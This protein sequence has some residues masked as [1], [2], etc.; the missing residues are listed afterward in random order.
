MTAL[1]GISFLALEAIGGT[2][3]LSYGFVN[4]VSAILAVGTIIFLTGLPISYHAAKLGTD[5]D[6]LTRGAGFGYIGSTV[7]SLIYASFTFIFFALEATILS[8]ALELTLD[9]PLTMGY[10]LSSLA[11]IPLVTHGITLISRFQ[12]WTHP[13]WITLQIIPLLCI[14]FKSDDALSLWTGYAPKSVADG[15]D[16]AAFGAA[17]VVVFSLI[18]QVGEQV[19]FLRFLPENNRSR[20][21][22]WM[23]LIFAGPGWIFPGLIKII[24]GSFLAV[25]AIN[26]GI[27]FER[28]SDPNQMY[29]IAFG[30]L[31]STP[32]L[33]LLLTGIFVVL[34]QLKINVTN[35]YAGSIA[36]SNFFSRATQN[37]PGRVVW[38]VFNVVIA[39]MLMELGVYQALKEILGMFAI[40]AI[41]WVGSLVADLTINRP[42][43]LRPRKIEFKRAHLYDINPVGIGSM[44]VASLIGLI[45][46]AGLFGITFQAMSPYLTLTVTFFCAP[47]IAWL[48]KGRYYIARDADSGGN[49]PEQVCCICEH[50]FEPE[51]M[52]LCPAYVGAICSLCCSL[53]SRCHDM[54]KTDAG[55]ADQISLAMKKV[56]PDA[57]SGIVTAKLGNFFG[58]FVL[59]GILMASLLA[60]VYFQITSD[61]SIDKGV[62]TNALIN[63]FFIL[64]IISGVVSWMFSL[65]HESR[66]LALEESR[67][68]TDLLIAEI[69]AHQITDFKLQQA[70]EVA[71]AANQAKSR[72]LTGI[73]HELRSPLNAIL[74]YAQLLEKDQA[75]P[76][77]RRD[78][79]SVIRRSGEHLA[80]LIEGLLDISRIEAGRLQLS[81]NDVD[82]LAML[83][84]IVNMFKVQSLAKGI[85]F[86]HER[87]TPL[88][89]TIRTDEKRLRQILINLIS[90]A[91]KYTQQGEVY[92]S[93]SYRN[94]VAVFSVKD[95]GE[96]IEPDDIEKIFQPFE[97]IRKAGAPYIPGTG[98]GLTITRF[99]TDIMGGEITVESNP[100]Q[101]SLFKVSLMLSSVDT[102]RSP[103]DLL[104]AI[105]S[106]Y[107]GNEQ[108][109]FIVDDDPNHRSLLIDMLQ[110]LGFNVLHAQD[111][112]TCLDMLQYCKKNPQLFLLD[113][114][115]PGMSGWELAGRIRSLIPSAAVIMVSANAYQPNSTFAQHLPHDAY[116]VKPI[117]LTDMMDLIQKY[118]PIRWIYSVDGSVSS[119][120]G[121]N[122][123]PVK[124]G[125]G[126][127]QALAIKPEITLPA[128]QTLDRADRE[129]MI[130][131]AK[132]GYMNQLIGFIKVLEED[133]KLEKQHVARLTNLVRNYRFDELIAY[134]E[135]ML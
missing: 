96:G 80:D 18:A 48:T 101:G 135:E 49:H 132:I 36:W 23:A 33:P 82:F 15:F 98:L 81:K 134:L 55:M 69:K 104:S 91:V 1:G 123:C 125:N 35:A 20:R 124:V 47:L 17:S 4:A 127:V 25:L 100:G 66:K 53:D 105:P 62:I 61:E 121:E 52:S 84:Q 24:I 108:T 73:S 34:S 68:Q 126:S 19:D 46:Y 130:Q 13:I 122:N 118:L 71:E 42:L 6:L 14:A 114:A 83:D 99:L 74:G 131:L 85:Q 97:R 10:L 41:A 86:V 102:I 65:L 38:L 76:D 43:G 28:A 95:T 29:L 133:R 2:L 11:V 3:T 37:H 70:K 72:Y 112:L 9:L 94:Q 7:T 60:L 45:T 88:P 109:V 31:T 90:N 106:G 32:D 78:A 40:I 113:I 115:M 119:V 107:E 27:G 5:I 117:K 75:I 64:L 21:S 79:L 129:T 92:F 56:V 111:G 54:C 128:H 67:H 22:W 58:L 26:H 77:N 59:T 116:L 57:W 39:L 8:M 89:K 30:Y 103:R 50:H 44:L 16:L 12:V 93:V 87:L 110:P 120:N 63:I 51:D